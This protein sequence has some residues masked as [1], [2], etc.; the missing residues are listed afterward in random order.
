M[1]AMR[2]RI[3]SHKTSRNSLQFTIH[4]QIL[5]KLNAPVVAVAHSSCILCILFYIY[6]IAIFIISDAHSQS[7]SL[8]RTHFHHSALNLCMSPS[9]MVSP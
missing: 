5:E 8:V 1:V 7:F 4:A 9:I 6:L 2:I 3:H